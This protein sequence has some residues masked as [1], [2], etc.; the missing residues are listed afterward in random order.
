MIKDLA[1]ILTSSVVLVFLGMCTGGLIIFGMFV[2]GV[3]PTILTFIVAY[4]LW[5][6][7]AVYRR[8]YE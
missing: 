2:I 7:I 3:V 4:A 8:W 5:V 6:G 1:I